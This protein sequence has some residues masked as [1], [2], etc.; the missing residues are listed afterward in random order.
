[1][2]DDHNKISDLAEE[3]YEIYSRAQLQIIGNIARRAGTE[4]AG[5]R[6][7]E[8]AKLAQINALLGE[9]SEVMDAAGS[10]AVILATDGMQK[11]YEM[12][13][14]DIGEGIP[15]ATITPET[16]VDER[17]VQALAEELLGM[18]T[19]AIRGANYV[20]RRTI[21]ESTALMATG[22]YTR[23][24]AT[25]EALIRFAAQGVS[26][27][28]DKKGRQWSLEAYSR[29]ATRTSYVQANLS[30]TADRMRE[31]GYDKVI[32]S[33]HPG[34]SELCAPHENHIYIMDIS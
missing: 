24:Q 33:A 1:M 29:M 12:G 32:V 34:P 30:G 5:A 7:W 2:A 22:N 15:M 6:S 8:R 14:A 11:S 26:G 19:N 23:R 31:E 9:V 13:Y 25:Q 20:Y 4:E 10:E 27:F 3:V 17:K 21:L 18:K 16:Q 28:R